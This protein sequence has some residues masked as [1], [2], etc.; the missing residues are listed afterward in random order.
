M[1]FIRDLFQKRLDKQYWLHKQNTQNDKCRKYSDNAR[2][3]EN[4]SATI[5]QTI[6]RTFSCERCKKLCDLNYTGGLC[7]ECWMEDY[8]LKKYFYSSYRTRLVE[9]LHNNGIEVLEESTEGIFEYGE[10]CNKVTEYEWMKVVHLRKNE[11]ALFTLHCRG[12]TFGF[13]DNGIGLR[14]L[15]L[16][17]NPEDREWARKIDIKNS[18]LAIC[19]DGKELYCLTDEGEIKST[20]PKWKTMKLLDPIDERRKICANIPCDQIQKA[21]DMRI[22]QSSSFQWGI[23][24]I[25]DGFTFYDATNRVFFRAVLDDNIYHYNNVDYKVIE[26][27]SV[28]KSIYEDM[29]TVFRRT[30]TNQLSCFAFINGL[31]V[32]INIKE[33]KPKN[34]DAFEKTFL[35]W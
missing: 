19:S 34:A 4:V 21:L 11:R 6:R 23:I 9:T 31:P 13:P 29:F 3:R 18:L 22:K 17:S 7:F 30:K 12:C 24:S 16:S 32:D 26:K 33:Y 10:P 35:P 8:L 15:Y 28:L 27:D 25:L 14:Y 5:N 1:G 2:N 20:T